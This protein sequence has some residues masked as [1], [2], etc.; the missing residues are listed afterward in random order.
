MLARQ[1]VP[2]Q[3]VQRS[4]MSN[5]DV[6]FAVRCSHLT[7]YWDAFCPLQALPVLITPGLSVEIQY[8][9]CELGAIISI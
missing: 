7:P 4:S 6:L 1:N 9:Y 3:Y 8:N 5:F 2:H